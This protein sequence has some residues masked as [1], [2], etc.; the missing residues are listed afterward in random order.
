MSE[1]RTY[2]AAHIRLHRETHAKHEGFGTHTHPYLHD[3]IR[4]VADEIVKAEGRQPTLLDY[5]CGKGSFMEE[6]RKLGLFASARG[7]DPAVDA[8]TRKPEGTFDVV[9]CL[10]VLDQA[11]SQFTDAIVRDVAGYATHTAIFS[12]ISKQWQKKPATP[13]FVLRQMI[14]KRMKVA[15]MWIRPSQG[16]EIADGAALERT[17]IVARPL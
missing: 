14:E 4:S 6:I 17:I 15:R 11:E 5:G 8:F 7:F 13:A 12:L 16:I 2:S 9:T 1:T 3:T 10:D